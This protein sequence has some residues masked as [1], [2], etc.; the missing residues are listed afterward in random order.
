MSFEKFIRE[1][2][3]KR[4]EPDFRQIASQLKRGQ[5]DLRTAK[6]V[7]VSDPTWAFTISYHAML[8][9]G[10]ALMYSNGYLPTAKQSHKTIIEFT[11]SV[12]GPE[13]VNVMN[14]FSRMRRQRHDFIYDSEN[15][16]AVSQARTAIE[17]AE[18]LTERIIGLVRKGNPQKELFD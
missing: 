16:I 3:I 12:L 18:K 10:R 14:R 13:Y 15:H 17:T 1:N 8:R 4:R 2:L 7:L 9:A 6:K 11:K 5:K